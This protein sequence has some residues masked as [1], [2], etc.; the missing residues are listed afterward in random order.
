VAPILSG[1]SRTGVEYMYLKPKMAVAT[2][3]WAHTEEMRAEVVSSLARPRQLARHSARHCRPSSSSMT[4]LSSGSGGAPGRLAGKSTRGREARK[5]SAAMTGSPRHQEE[6]LVPSASRE[7]RAFATALRGNFVINC[8]Q[9]C[10]V[11]GL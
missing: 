11:H 4:H 10:N 3:S 7:P 1:L 5:V 2:W 8:V 9:H 6:A